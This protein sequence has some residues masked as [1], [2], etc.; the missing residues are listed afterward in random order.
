MILEQGQTLLMIGDSITDCGRARPV[1]TVEDGLGNGYVNFVNAAIQAKCPELKIRILNTGVSGNRVTNLQNRWDKDVI[2]HKPDWLSIMIGINDVWR[3]F[4]SPDMEEQVLTEEFET[5]LD[6]LIIKTLP[7]L[8]GLIL[9]TPYL[10]E[11]DRA[12]PFRA[13]MDI[14]TAVVKKLAEKHSAVMADT[15]AGFD[16]YLKHRDKTELCGDRV[17][18]NAVGHMIIANAFLDAIGV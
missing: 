5:I 14:Y 4:D 12:D 11:P 15:Q 16:A 13:Q 2:A 9:I 3:Q 8:K 17:H 10:I 18:P 6:E 1:G 7:S